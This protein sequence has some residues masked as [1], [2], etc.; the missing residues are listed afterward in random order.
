MTAE[1]QPQTITLYYRQGGSDKVYSA[2]IEAKGAGFVVNFAFGRRG[3]TLQTGTK[4]AKPLDY[5]TARTIYDTLVREKMAKGYTPGQDGV[6]YQGTEREAAATGIFP[7]LLN[8]ID[9]DQAQRLIA[10]DDWWMQEKFDGKR[11]L[12][13]KDG[14]QAIGINRKGLVVALP[15]SIAEQAMIAGG[16]QWLMDGEAVGDVYFAFDLLEQDGVDLRKEPYSRRLEVLSVIVVP[17]GK[18]SIRVRATAIGIA[19]KQEM[20]AALHSLKAEGA[21]FKRHAAPYTPGRPA[22][23]GDQ[24]KLKFTAT[25][26]CIVA[27]PSKAK[28]SVALELLDGEKRVAVGNVTIAPNQPIPK[29]GSV[30][31]IKYL[32][33]FLGGSLFQPVCLGVRDDVGVDACTIGQ[34]KFKAADGESEGTEP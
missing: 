6:P 20:L 2:V 30:V 11:I 10:D 12:I 21:V 13:K 17:G 25:A 26:S 7:Q 9:E 18:G 8:P 32:Y 4:T 23:G 27:K 28:R 14:D 34:I 33:A 29:A 5:Q 3:T 22:S 31:E 15:Q 19:Q 16:R 1:T 24:L